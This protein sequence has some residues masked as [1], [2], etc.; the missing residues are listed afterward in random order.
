MGL[1]IMRFA[2]SFFCRLLQEKPGLEVAAFYIVGWVGVKLSVLTLSHPEVAV[3]SEHFPSNPIWKISFYVVLVG[4]A[5]AGWFLS[6]SEKP[7]KDSEAIA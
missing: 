1:V 6:K 3:L 4:I 5:A 7:N 2:A